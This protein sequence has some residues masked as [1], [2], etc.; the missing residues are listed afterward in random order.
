MAQRS[1]LLTAKNTRA[2]LYTP[3]N[4]H[5]GIVPLE[6]MACGLPVLAVNSG[7][8]TETII[9]LSKSG[10]TGLLREPD[11][12]EW[13]K[14]LKELVTLPDKERSEV[15]K[16]AKDRIKQHFSAET[17][18]KEMEAACREAIGLN[19]GATV[20][21]QVGDNLIWVGAGMVAVAG[22]GLALVWATVGL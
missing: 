18:G 7:G 10:G 20:R 8:P 3:S 12:M 22:A 1:Y 14:A 4:E 19:D 11:E 13:S 6:A 15:S 16:S 2:L 17:L 9:D 5:F 21:D